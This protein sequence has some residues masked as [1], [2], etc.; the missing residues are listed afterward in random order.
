MVMDPNRTALRAECEAA[1]AGVRSARGT[2]EVLPAIER[3]CRAL[4]DLA[5]ADAIV[6]RGDA[7]PALTRDIC[8]RIAAFRQ[9][10]RSIQK[11]G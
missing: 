3:V 6:E 5:L 4:S 1:F 10:A 11:L 9:L 8:L 7:A 2:G